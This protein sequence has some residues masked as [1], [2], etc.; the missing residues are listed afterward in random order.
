MAEACRPLPNSLE[1]LDETTAEY[2]ESLWRSGAP[3]GKAVEFLSAVARLLPRARRGIP[4]T[5][6]L[7]SNWR[8]TVTRN[9]ALPFPEDMVRGLAGLALARGRW[10][11]GLAVLVGF[12]GLLRPAEL[13]A[14]TAEDVVFQPRAPQTMVLI[15]RD[16]KSGRRNN[17]DEKVV[18][19]DL[20]IAVGLRAHV[21]GRAPEER[22]FPFQATRFVEELREYVRE[23]GMANTAVS[24]YS[25]RRGGATWYFT[26]TGSMSRT[27][28]HGRWGSER[29]AR[30]Y[31]DGA[32]AQLAKA[33]LHDDTTKV[34]RA[35]GA[36][37][38]RM[39]QERLDQHRLRG[40][41]DPRAPPGECR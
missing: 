16:T 4:T 7:V 15:L 28:V 19:E 29:T 27:T 38:R 2:V 36:V 12:M 22:L 39:L 40:V 37:A 9:R 41:G 18:I 14:L 6:F 34:F 20:Y 8:R 5:A 25:L 3:E 17:T 24:G 33:R 35:A 31:I 10:D 32:M 26:T 21:A 11:Y 13:F 30:I 1:E 23:A